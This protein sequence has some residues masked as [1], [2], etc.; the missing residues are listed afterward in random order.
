LNTKL[1]P[2]FSSDQIIKSIIEESRI[3]S[4]VLAIIEQA[5]IDQENK[6]HAV[7]AKAL[8]EKTSKSRL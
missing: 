7:I 5:L 3:K 8:D 1:S 2:I 4:H 6:A